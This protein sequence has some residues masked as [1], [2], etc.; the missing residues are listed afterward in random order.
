MRPVYL[1]GGALVNAHG[2]D[3]G[4][5]ATRCLARDVSPSTL[6]FGYLGKQV[7]L[8]YFS[9]SGGTAG[10]AELLTAVA[11]RALRDIDARRRAAMPLLLGTSSLDIGEQERLYSSGGEPPIATRSQG[12]IAEEVALRLGLGGPRHTL[13]TACSAGANALLYAAWMIRRGEAEQALVLGVELRNLVSVLGFH[14]MLLLAPDACRPFDA[15]R[16]GIVLG[17]AVA[18]AVLSAAPPPAKRVWR[19]RGGAT[20]CDTSHPTNSSAG[21]VARVVR[22]ALADAGRSPAQLACI[23][24]HGTGTPANDEAEAAGLA[25]VFGAAGAPP[26]TS[27][28]PVLGHTLGACG[29][30]ETL[31]MLDCLERGSIPPTAGCTSPDPAL[32]LRPLDHPIPYDGGA[33]LF[34]YFGFGGNNCALVM[35]PSHA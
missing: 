24:A 2:D 30:M 29:V 27:L 17:E 23:K 5:S 12:D 16:R 4:A 21:G 1:A 10:I 28:K 31:V 32:A 9:L 22:D 15:A 7:E 6:G 14:G 25:Q 34:N 19:L 20:L 18:A 35:E 8:P 11:G 3:T 26:M 13:F 33:V